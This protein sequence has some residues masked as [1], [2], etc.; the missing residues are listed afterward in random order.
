LLNLVE[1][2]PRPARFG[3]IVNEERFEKFYVF[4]LS[5]GSLPRV[6]DFDLD[7]TEDLLAVVRSEDVLSV[8]RGVTVPYT[9][10]SV[11]RLGNQIDTLLVKANLHA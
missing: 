8:I 10:E 6:F 3:S 2:K 4:A 11:V 1:Y 7:K 9:H 5:D